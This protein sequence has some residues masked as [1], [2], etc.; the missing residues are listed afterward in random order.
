MEEV[1]CNLCGSNNTHIIFQSIDYNFTLDPNEKFY[2]SKCNECGLI[3]QNPRVEWKSMGKHYPNDYEDYRLGKKGVDRNDV[4]KL[5]H[6]KFYQLHQLIKS[7]RILDVGSGELGFLSLCKNA[8]FD[9]YGCELSDVG[10]ERAHREGIKLFVG[11]FLMAKY[12]KKFFDVITF[13]HSLEHFPDPAESIKKV[14][15]ILKDNGLVIIAIPNIESIQ[16]HLF[17]KYWVHLDVPRHY[18]FF[19]PKTLNKLLGKNGFKTIKTKHF[20]PFYNAWGFGMGML[21]MFGL[22]DMLKNPP[23]PIF[24][25]LAY[26]GFLFPS[27]IES[28]LRRGGTFITFAQKIAK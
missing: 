4:K 18:Y 25:N 8:G 27:L 21:N 1:S 23:N 16:A 7:G 22:R 14:F 9:A 6:Y 28:I 12:P 13:W 24:K 15:Q 5:E 20:I 3:F 11:D 19:S 2:I 17:G 10:L 26:M